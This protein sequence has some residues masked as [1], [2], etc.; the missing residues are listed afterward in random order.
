MNISR[1]K[2]QSSKLSCQQIYRRLS[3]RSNN[4]KP[5]QNKVLVK[6]KAK[7]F[8]KSRIVLSNFGRIG[9]NLSSYKLVDFTLLFFIQKKGLASAKRQKTVY[10]DAKI[11]ESR[12]KAFVYFRLRKSPNMVE[13]KFKF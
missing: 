10:D 8:A 3:I 12:K 11:G 2:P 1:P 4:E 13:V 9:K 6:L 7:F 5:D